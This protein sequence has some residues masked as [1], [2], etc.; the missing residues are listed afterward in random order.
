MPWSWVWYGFLGSLFVGTLLQDAE[1]QHILWSILPVGA[2]FAWSSIATP[3]SGL[4]L[5]Q[6]WHALLLLGV[7]GAACALL[8]TFLLHGIQ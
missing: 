6:A 5:H 4:G 2:R 1:V 7:S 3:L 8:L